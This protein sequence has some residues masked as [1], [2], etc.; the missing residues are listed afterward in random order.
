MLENR[1][2]LPNSVPLGS[3]AQGPAGLMERHLKDARKA[4]LRKSGQR[5][6]R[7]ES[8]FVGKTLLF[9]AP[10]KTSF[11]IGSIA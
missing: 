11:A 2:A 10:P 6:I 3:W 7:F 5:M 4:G 1:P 9:Q 8:R